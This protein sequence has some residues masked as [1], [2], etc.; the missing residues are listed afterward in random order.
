MNE[1]ELVYFLALGLMAFSLIVLGVAIFVPGDRE[2]RTLYA[3][4]MGNFSG[5]LFMYIRMKNGG[6]DAGGKS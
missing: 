1:R 3:G 4:V 2:L 5:A 6:D